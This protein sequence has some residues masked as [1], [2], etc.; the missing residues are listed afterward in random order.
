MERGDVRAACEAGE[1]LEASDAGAGEGGEVA[2]EGF[3][4]GWG[5][6][7]GGGVLADEPHGTGSPAAYARSERGEGGV[8]EACEGEGWGLECG[9]RP[10]QQCVVRVRFCGVLW[11]E[12]HG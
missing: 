6:A 2:E 1:P 3:E 7:A 10:C 12:S 9:K 4:L 8:I 11:E 5:N